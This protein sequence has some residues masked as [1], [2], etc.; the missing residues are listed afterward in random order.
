MNQSPSGQIL[1]QSHPGVGSVDIAKCN[2]VCQNSRVFVCNCRRVLF[3]NIAGCWGVF[4][5]VVVSVNIAKCLSFNVSVCL[6]V[7]KIWCLYV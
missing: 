6:S 4:K 5:A 2:L 3:V 1:F 7:N